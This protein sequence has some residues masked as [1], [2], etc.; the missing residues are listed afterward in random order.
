MKVKI[1]LAL[2]S[3]CISMHA[4]DHGTPRGKPY[5]GITPRYNL[6]DSPRGDTQLHTAIRLGTS[7]GRETAIHLLACGF[8]VDQTSSQLGHTAPQVATSSLDPEATELLLERN[9]NVSSKVSNL[10]PLDLVLLSLQ[11]TFDHDEGRMPFLAMRSP[12]INEL[13]KKTRELHARKVITLLLTHIP[14]RNLIGAASA[15]KQD[16]FFCWIQSIIKTQLEKAQTQCTELDPLLRL[17]TENEKLTQLCNPMELSD[18]F[19]ETIEKNV[20][21]IL[22]AASKLQ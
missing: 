9:A 21:T 8:L 10:T 6:E 4:M 15:L 17:Q 13:D 7:G 19:K 12:Q 14:T 18:H 16:C 20:F 11:E 1:I 3:A 22:Q 2:V 5:L